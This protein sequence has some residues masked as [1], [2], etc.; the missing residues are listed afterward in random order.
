MSVTTDQL[1]AWKE[2]YG[3]VLEI[4]IDGRTA[5]FRPL[6]DFGIL[7]P[8]FAAMQRSQAAFA[9][10]LVNNAWLGGDEAVRTDDDLFAELTE[11]LADQLDIPEF[12]VKPAGEA[13]YIVTVDGRTCRLRRPRREEIRTAQERNSRNQPFETNLWLVPRLWLEGDEELKTDVRLL[14]GLL[15]AIGEL[16]ERK[17]AQLKKH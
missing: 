8:A 17:V 14:L 11:V 1:A 7:K 5:Y 16:R 2:K 6:Y 15:P 12:T 13:S 10:S 4:E 9:E 3:T